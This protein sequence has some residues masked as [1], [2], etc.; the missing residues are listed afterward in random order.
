M[1]G[2]SMS[3]RPGPLGDAAQATAAVNVYGRSPNGFVTAV[4]GHGTVVVPHTGC[5]ARCYGKHATVAGVYAP[6]ARHARH[7]CM[8]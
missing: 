5:N 4:D 8:Q 3:A 6:H 2:D 1:I 7:V